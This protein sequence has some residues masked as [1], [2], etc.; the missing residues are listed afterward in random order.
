MISFRFAA[1]VGCVVCSSGPVFAAE[2]GAYAAQI[3]QVVRPVVEFHI[4]ELALLALSFLVVTLALER[5]YALVL[6]GEWF[7]P[8]AALRAVAGARGRKPGESALVATFQQVCRDCPGPYT[9]VLAQ[10][11]DRAGEPLPVLTAVCTESLEAEF[12]RASQ[13]TAHLSA[14]ARL[15]PFLGLLGTVAGIIVALD[16]TAGGGSEARSAVVAKGLAAALASTAA[17]ILVAL[18]ATA[19][20]HLS[21]QRLCSVFV[22]MKASLTSVLSPLAGPPA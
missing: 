5:L 3:N 2:P 9:G 8:S 12:D 11:I 20:A 15:A 21:R 4:P 16:P 17:G 18:V 19:V 1:G 13:P 7:L 14:I 6:R 22:Q 10:C